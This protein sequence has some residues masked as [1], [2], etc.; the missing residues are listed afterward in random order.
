MEVVA[1]NVNWI[2]IEKRSKALRYCIN[3]LEKDGYVTCDRITNVTIRV[4]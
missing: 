1:A 3:F 4:F 2:R